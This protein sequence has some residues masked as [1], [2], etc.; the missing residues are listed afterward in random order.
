MKKP[1]REAAV[2]N[3]SKKE[4]LWNAPVEKPTN[5]S[6]LTVK[7]AFVLKMRLHTRDLGRLLLFLKELMQTA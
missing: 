4:S 3:D 2:Q 7:F 5:G 1:P 6:V